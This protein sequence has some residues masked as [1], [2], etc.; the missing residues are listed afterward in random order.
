M[1]SVI[2]V[3]CRVEIGMEPDEKVCRSFALHRP[4]SHSSSSL[5]EKK[6]PRSDLVVVRDLTLGDDLLEGLRCLL[7][8][9]RRLLEGEPLVGRDPW[10]LWPAQRSHRRADRYS[11]RFDP[12][13]ES[14]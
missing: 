2:V 6:I 9:G 10:L 1:V 3:V 14:Q 8:V 12:L 11:M 4:I 7:E 13:V 5:R